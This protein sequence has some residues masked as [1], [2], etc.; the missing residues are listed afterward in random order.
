MQKYVINKT[1]LDP[2]SC[3]LLQMKLQE[4]MKI[5]QIHFRTKLKKI[6]LPLVY[7][8]VK[9]REFNKFTIEIFFTGQ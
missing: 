1:I 6:D 7:H 5:E 3:L 8:T 4:Q 9:S 2:K